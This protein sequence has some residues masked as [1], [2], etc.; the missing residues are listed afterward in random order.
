[1]AAKDIVRKS[2]RWTQRTGAFDGGVNSFR[3]CQHTGRSL[4]EDDYNRTGMSFRVPLMKTPRRL[5]YDTK[6][7]RMVVGCGNAVR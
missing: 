1:M 3:G 5:H 7:Q 6:M 4:A 2:F